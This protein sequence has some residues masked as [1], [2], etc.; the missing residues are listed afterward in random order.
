MSDDEILAEALKEFENKQG[1]QGENTDD[2]STNNQAGNNNVA[3]AGNTGT[4][5]NDGALTD[6]ERSEQLKGQLNQKFAK[7]DDLMLGERETIGRED[8]GNGGGGFGTSDS[9]EGEDAQ[10]EPLQTASMGDGPNVSRTGL[11][12][13]K[14]GISD[15]A[16]PP[17]DIGDGRDDDII[18]RQLREAA[19]KEQDPELRAKLWDEY[20]KYKRGA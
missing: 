19:M 17:A 3:D 16:P 5:T 6:E 2:A 1:Q 15:S 8:G 10:D 12:S 18:A 11:K 14:P 7:F 9:D 13:T 4:G 20:R